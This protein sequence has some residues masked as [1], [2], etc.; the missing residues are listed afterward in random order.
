MDPREWILLRAGGRRSPL[1]GQR[2]RI[3]T[4][5]IES[6][7]QLFT[8]GMNKQTDPVVVRDR[9]AAAMRVAAGWRTAG[10]DPHELTPQGVW[11]WPEL[12]D[13]ELVA[14]SLVLVP[15][16]KRRLPAAAWKQR[17]TLA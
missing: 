17:R 5:V 6:V 14:L 13:D 12:T 2:L 10:D 3:P 4:R 15:K 11:T 9:L 8:K 7:L 16:L 1:F